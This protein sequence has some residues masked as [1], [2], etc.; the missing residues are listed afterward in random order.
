[1]STILESTHV[2]ST[3]SHDPNTDP[4][5]STLTTTPQSF[6]QPTSLLHT[7]SLLAAKSY[8]DPVAASIRESQTSRLVELR[9]NRKRK[10]GGDEESED[11]DD[12]KVL[13]IQEVYTEGFSV[14]QVWE[15]VR[16]I[17][18]GVEGEVERDVKKL[19]IEKTTGKDVGVKMVRFGDDG[20][21]VG[22]EEDD[23]ELEDEEDGDLDDDEALDDYLDQHGE[24][25]DFDDEMGDGAEEEELEDDEDEEDIEVDSADE[26]MGSDLEEEDGAAKTYVEDPNGLNDG[27]FSIDDFNRQTQFLEQQDA[28]GDQDEAGSDE[29]EV[30]WEANPFTSAATKSKPRKEANGEDDDEEEEYSEEEDGPTFGNA[31]LNAPFSDDDDDEAMGDEDEDMEDANPMLPNLANTNEIKYSDFFEPPPRKE[32]KRNRPLPKTQ[33]SK[34]QQAPEDMQT[35]MNRAMADVRRDLFD[36]ED[37]EGSEEGSDAEGEAGNKSTHEK[38]RAKLAAEIRRLEA[39]NVA[40]RDWQMSGEARAIDRPVNSLIEEDLEFERTGKPVT[41]VTA[42]MTEE[43]EDLIKRRIVA[44]EFDE[45]LRRSAA[46]EAVTTS[47]RGLFELDDTKPRQGLGEMYEEAHLKSTDPNFVDE[48]DAKTKKAHAEID[49][50]WKSTVEKLDALSNWHF[51]PKVAAAEVTVISD[52]PAISMEDARPTA[53]D[54][55]A[56]ESMLAPQEVYKA[57]G[58]KDSREGGQVTLKS[59]TT[60]ANEEMTREERLRRR[61][62]E[63]ERMKKANSNKVSAEAV[64]EAAAG[65][66]KVDK[67][68]KKED[69]LTELRKG[70]VKVIGKK[71]EGLTDVDGKKVREKTTLG[72]G[73]LKL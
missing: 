65:G 8:L 33:P 49:A 53:A 48:R 64:K 34:Q 10:R 55:M 20:F 24:D 62:R 7:S 1:M 23:E 73:G 58:K 6:L 66:K 72:G 36:D 14:Q 59:G 63:K 39:E 27:F 25:L 26:M 22:S 67:K 15:Q 3:S 50:L 21:E 13:G 68:A 41:V 61:R 19:G 29:E 32:S 69:I 31:D 46:S 42:E 56:T 5:L 35:E 9:K 45:V 70:G 38:Q 60:L 43:I 37:S 54:G 44:K 28:R 30:D 18:E 47:R 40:K 2:S 71:G 16:R 4:L 17:V 11:E 51:R 57:G 52:A 12:V